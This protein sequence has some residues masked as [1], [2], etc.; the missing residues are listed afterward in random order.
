MDSEALRRMYV[1]EQLTT[2]QIAVRLGCTGTTIRRRLREFHIPVRARGP[3]VR[4]RGVLLTSS[5]WTPELAYVVGLITTDGNFSR[6]G[7]HLAIPSKD[8]SLLESIRSCLGLTNAICKQSTGG[9]RYIYRLQW[10]DRAFYDWLLGIGLTPAKSLTL[11]A[12]AVPDEYFADFFRGCIDGDGS[13][14]RYTDRGFGRPSRGS[15][16]SAGRSA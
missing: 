3:I 9:P 6:D 2:E 15:S 16:A 10:S 1:D 5:V 13:V 4:R 14:V 12:L 11:Q 8:R 7:R